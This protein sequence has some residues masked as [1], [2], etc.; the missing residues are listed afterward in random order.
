LFQFYA[1]GPYGQGGSASESLLLGAGTLLTSLPLH[2]L[3]SYCTVLYQTIPNRH[4]RSGMSLYLS[5][6]LWLGKNLS[7]K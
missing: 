6:I 2:S 5:F 3:V 1:I 4:F 7:L